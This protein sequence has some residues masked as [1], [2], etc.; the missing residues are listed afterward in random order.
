MLIS[1][2]SS[3]PFPRNPSSTFGYHFNFSKFSFGHYIYIQTLATNLYFSSLDRQSNIP[4]EK[5]GSQEEQRLANF[6]CN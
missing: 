3:F 5:L 4:E 1:K 6:Y 2:A